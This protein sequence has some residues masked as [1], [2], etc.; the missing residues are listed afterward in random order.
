MFAKTCLSRLQRL[1][2][3]NEAPINQPQSVCAE[4]LFSTPINTN[5]DAP[6]VSDSISKLRRSQLL[7]RSYLNP[8]LRDSVNSNHKDPDKADRSPDRLQL[9][10]PPFHQLHHH[11]HHSEDQTL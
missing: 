2:A 3:N 1:D 6:S 11:E 5:V 4:S 8:S 7:S 10:I 9:M